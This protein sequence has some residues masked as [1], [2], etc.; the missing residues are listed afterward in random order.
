VAQLKLTTFLPTFS[1]F[2]KGLTNLLHLHMQARELDGMSRAN[3]LPIVNLSP[4]RPHE[5]QTVCARLP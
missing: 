1:V 3:S 2:C 4:W 5:S